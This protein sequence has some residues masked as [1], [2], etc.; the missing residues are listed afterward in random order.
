MSGSNMTVQGAIKNKVV[1]I[2]NMLGLHPFA[3]CGLRNPCRTQ[4]LL[5]CI[6]YL[7]LIQY[8]YDP[9][10]LPSSASRFIF[11]KVYL[12][13]NLSREPMSHVDLLLD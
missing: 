12:R 2:F 10:T 8:P 7:T 13:S 11:G 9:S 6:L 4:P 5:G 1:F 3:R